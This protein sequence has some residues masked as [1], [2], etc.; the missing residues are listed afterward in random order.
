MFNISKTKNEYESVYPFKYPGFKMYIL[1]NTHY[2][3]RDCIW[4]KKRKFCTYFYLNDLESGL[5]ICCCCLPDDLNRLSELKETN[6][7]NKKRLCLPKYRAAISYF[8][9]LSLA[10]Y[11]ERAK[12]RGM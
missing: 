5:N 12:K 4:K 11:K 7:S 2:F 3:R 8:F 6:I 10:L 1:E 9:N